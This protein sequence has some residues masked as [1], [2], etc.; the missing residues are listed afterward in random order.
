MFGL[1][2]YSGP[3]GFGF[4]TALLVVLGGKKELVLH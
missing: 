3:Y 1:F 2:M 4:S